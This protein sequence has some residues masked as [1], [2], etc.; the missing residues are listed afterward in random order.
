[1]RLLFHMTSWQY[2]NS[3]FIFYSGLSLII[4]NHLQTKR[5]SSFKQR[6]S[7]S[8]I[9]YV[10]LIVINLLD[11]LYIIDGKSLIKNLNLDFNQYQ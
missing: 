8:L 7:E 1:M 10:P 9:I 4:F 3:N 5:S 6:P 2:Q 11:S